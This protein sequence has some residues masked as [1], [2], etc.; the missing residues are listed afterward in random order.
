M[1]HV[2]LEVPRDRT[3]YADLSTDHYPWPEVFADLRA[4]SFLSGVLDV[5][6]GGQRGRFVWVGGDGLG[7]HIGTQDADLAT[8]ARTFPRAQ[9]SLYLLDAT[10]AEMTWTHRT[11][12]PQPGQAAWSD[13]RPQLE[14]TRFSGIVLAGDRASFWQA[15]RALGG[16]LPAAHDTPATITVTPD[17][18]V[19]DMVGFWN[20]V[21][22]HV[23]QVVP[24]GQLWQS[25]TVEL[26]DDHPC[27]DPFAREVTLDGATLIVADDV[28]TDE[29]NPALRDAFADMM[30]RSGVRVVNL[31]LGELRLRP[32]WSL[33]GIGDIP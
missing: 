21:L 31:P 26:A 12:A 15:G 7:G 2:W 25:T 5:T 20:A 19:Q 16:V 10:V 6:A 11:A 27:L 13:A 33:S 8:I 14:S 28:P 18:G 1:A 3:A 17:V 30:R 24:L 23:S 4:R 32:E 22:S 9:V 29:L